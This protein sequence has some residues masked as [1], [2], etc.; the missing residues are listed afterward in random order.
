MVKKIAL[1][2][3]LLLIMSACS[4]DKVDE[5]TTSNTFTLKSPENKTNTTTNTTPDN[6]NGEEVELTEQ[7]LVAMDLLN[8][9]IFVDECNAY[10]KDDSVKKEELDAYLTNCVEQLKLQASIVVDSPDEELQTEITPPTTS[11]STDIPPK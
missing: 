2:L 6:G 11:T 1:S 7:D 8:E 9:E 3:L 4:D 10:A 5:N